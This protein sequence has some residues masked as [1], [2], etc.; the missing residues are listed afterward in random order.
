MADNVKFPPGIVYLDGTT[1]WLAEGFHRYAASEMAGN[2]AML[3]EVR[4]GT[5]HDAVICSL[6]ANQAHG[7]YR[8]SADKRRTV[9]V[10]LEDDICQKWTDREIAEVCGVSHTLV[11]D[12]RNP[13][14][15]EARKAKKKAAGEKATPRDKPT[16][17]PGV[18]LS[19]PPV[20]AESA[21]NSQVI[22]KGAEPA[23]ESRT[24]DAAAGILETALDDANDRIAMLAQGDVATDEEKAMW[25]QGIDELRRGYAALQAERDSISHQFNAVVRENGE[26]KTHIKRLQKKLDQAGR[27]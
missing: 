4:Q 14:K 21:K 2:A 13:A 16:S 26:L 6:K 17:K 27:R 10:A 1:R 19:D 25:K 9:E 3:V 5:R 12:V 18:V 24:D 8:S 11:Q 15:V 23:D 7:I 22:H 20:L